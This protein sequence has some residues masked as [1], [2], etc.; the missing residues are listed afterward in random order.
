MG[1]GDF[2]TASG[3]SKDS[4]P[5]NLR[6]LGLI[7]EARRYFSAF[8]ILALPSRYE[9]FPYVVLEAMAASIPIVSTRVSGAAELIDAQQIGFVVPNEDDAT[10]FAETIAALAQDPMMRGSMSRNCIRAVER[11]SA[12]AMVERT[13][14]LYK[15]LL[16]ETN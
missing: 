10:L 15:R 5:T 12:T 1:P 11:F 13:V 6:V 14:D 7:P 16:K 8:D 3:L 2:V 9:G 4:I